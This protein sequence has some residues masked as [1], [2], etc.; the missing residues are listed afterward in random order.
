MIDLSDAKD[1]VVGIG[2]E[3]V[4]SGTLNADERKKVEAAVAGIAVAMAT[5]DAVAVGNYKTG[6]NTWLGVAEVRAAQASERAALR[7]ASLGLDLAVKVALGLL[8]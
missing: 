3:L 6:L 8:A 7:L 4:R 5:G 2:E 1:A